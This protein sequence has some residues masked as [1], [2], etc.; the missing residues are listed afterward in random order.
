[1]VEKARRKP[2]DSEGRETPV[3]QWEV[4]VRDDQDEPLRHVGSVAA[5][6]ADDAVD[7]AARLFGWYAEDLWVCPAA[8]VERRSTRPLEADRPAEADS[9]SAEPR[10]YEETEGT[11]Q[12]TDP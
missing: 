2:V 8:A 1:M 4:F 3:P 10:V 12:V 5:T 11:P 6:D 9:D 7:H